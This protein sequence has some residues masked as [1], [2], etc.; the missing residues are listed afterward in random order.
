MSDTHGHD[1]GHG[2]DKKGADVIPL[3]A[4]RLVASF[5]D[6][7]HE[8]DHTP[9]RNLFGFLIVL[10]V[11]LVLT[12]AGVY[13]LFVS[14]ADAD[15][16]KAAN[17]PSKQLVAQA[18]RDADFHEHWGKVTREGQV[19]GYRM[20]I[21]EAARL[22]LANPARFAAAPPPADWVHPDDALKKK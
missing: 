4:T 13:Q 19:V 20:P 7:G 9:N 5:T 3:P 12:A 8:I 21:P 11:L 2:D 17:Q 1:H 16:E 10:S 22:V 14:K 6:G 18:A 15:I